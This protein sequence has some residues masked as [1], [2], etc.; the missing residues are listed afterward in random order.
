ML[1]EA[2]VDL[3]NQMLTYDPEKRIS[4]RAAL[5]HPWLSEAPLPQRPEVPRLPLAPE[6]RRRHEHRCGLSVKSLFLGCG[7]RCGRKCTEK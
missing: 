5:E 3:L 7:P 1:S 4:A 2:G 6:P